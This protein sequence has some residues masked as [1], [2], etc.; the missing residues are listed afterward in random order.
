LQN[1][2]KN[3]LSWRVRGGRFGADSQNPKCP[4][5]KSENLKRRKSNDT[6]DLQPNRENLKSFR[7]QWP[8]QFVE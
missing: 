1:D 4:Q 8:I 5:R 3:R 2:C 7:L 6:N